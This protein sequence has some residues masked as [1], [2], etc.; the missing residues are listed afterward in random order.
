MSKDRNLINKVQNIHEYESFDYETIGNKNGN[1][2]M[3]K[4][5]Y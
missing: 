4:D 2:I 5:L 3:K 1:S